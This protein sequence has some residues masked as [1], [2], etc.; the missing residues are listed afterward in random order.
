MFED[1]KLVN[2]YYMVS[3]CQFI[4]LV[5][6]EISGRFTKVYLFCD[7][8]ED[9]VVTGSDDM[10]LHS[11]CLCSGGCTLQS[12]LS[13]GSILLIIFFTVLAAYLV[14][15]KKEYSSAIKNCVLLLCYTTLCNGGHWS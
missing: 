15:G 6:A 14:V 13:P 4:P 8:N 7:T 3:D 10:Q 9:L 11:P 1:V 2:S 5:F 12:G